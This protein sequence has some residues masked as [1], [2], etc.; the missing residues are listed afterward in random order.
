[1]SR[2]HSQNVSD[3]LEDGEPTPNDIMPLRDRGMPVMQCH[4][5]FKNVE[6]HPPVQR[7]SRSGLSIFEHPQGVVKS[8]K[9]HFAQHTIAI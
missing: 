1:M 7:N 2:G 3:L 9:Y 6:R 4:T 8:C 5:L